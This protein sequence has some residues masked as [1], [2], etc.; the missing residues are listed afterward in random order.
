MCF[1]NVTSIAGACAGAWADTNPA[2][3]QTNGTTAAIRRRCRFIGRRLRPNMRIVNK[4][5]RGSFFAHPGFRPE[6]SRQI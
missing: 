3:A 6:L 5:G 4:R 1:V 2:M